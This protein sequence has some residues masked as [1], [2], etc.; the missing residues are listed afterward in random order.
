MRLYSGNRMVDIIAT[1]KNGVDWT[2]N[3]LNAGSL[4]YNEE[5]DAYEVED[6]DG[7][8]EFAEDWINCE[9]D[10]AD[11]EYDED[12]NLE[13]WEVEFPPMTKDGH[14]ISVG[15]WLTDETGIYM[16][17]ARGEK[18]ELKEVIFDD[19]DTDDFHMGEIRILTDAEI[20]K[21]TVC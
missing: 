4:D 12:N 20:G 16:V 18:T 9:G 17:W 2:I 8:I 14:Y 11:D 3:L 5:L 7:A 13:V 10:F 15:D 6:I 21:M 19:V 1:D